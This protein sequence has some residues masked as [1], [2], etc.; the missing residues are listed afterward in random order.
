[1]GVADRVSAI[2]MFTVVQ[3]G[4][5]FHKNASYYLIILPPL[6]MAV[7]LRLPQPWG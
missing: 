3:H 5:R 1:M 2:S 4:Y 6:A 7:Y